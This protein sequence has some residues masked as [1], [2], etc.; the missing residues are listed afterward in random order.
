MATKSIANHDGTTAKNETERQAAL[1]HAL[2]KI[3]Q[4]F[5]QGAVMRMGENTS[6]RIETNSTGILSLDVALG[7]GGFPKGRIIEIYGPESSGKTTLALAAT[8]SV[9]RNGGTVA[10]IDAE[11]AMDPKYAQQLGVNIDQLLLSQPDS[12]EEGLAIADALVAS[13]A[14]DLVVVDSVAALTPQAEINGEMGDAHVGLQAR[15]MS[16]ALRK[17]S[18]EI[19]RTKTTVIFINQLREKIGVMFGN[20]ET[21]PG[22]RALKFYATIRLDVRRGEKIKNGTEII[23]NQIKIKVAKNKV[24]APFKVAEIQNYYGKGFSAVGDVLGLAVE[25]DIAKKSGA[26][27]SYKGERIGQGLPNSTAYL[28]DHPDLLD[29]MSKEVRAKLLP[30]VDEKATDKPKQKTPEE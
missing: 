19:N 21:T 25:N 23:G 9:Q 13:S 4:S 5:G 28:T 22:G 17:L 24:A 26:W 29:E 11:N 18:G 2:K 14:V 27:Y 6:T 16:Q 8:A 3:R 7:V 30:E 20:P 12:G 1:D 10:Y 15:M